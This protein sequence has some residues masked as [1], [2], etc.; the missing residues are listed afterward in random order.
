[1][2]QAL[3]Y[4]GETKRHVGLSISL[5]TGG[6]GLKCFP[7]SNNDQMQDSSLDFTTK[8]A[9]EVDKTFQHYLRDSR[10]TVRYLVVSC[11]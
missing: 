1:M 8:Q 5:S 6:G 7:W 4:L 3:P 2:L 11:G 9:T 10:V